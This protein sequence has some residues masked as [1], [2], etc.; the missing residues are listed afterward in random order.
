MDKRFVDAS[1]DTVWAHK[2]LVLIR[3]EAGAP[4]QL[5]VQVLDVTDRQRS[6]EVLAHQALHDSLTGLPNRS[7]LLQRIEHAV[8][9]SRRDQ[10][11]LV[12]LIF[13]DLDRFKPINDTL[14]HSVGD[15][16]LA[17]VARRLQALVRAGDT[18]ARLGGDEFTILAE[19]LASEADA[20][21]IAKRVIEAVGRPFQA[22]ERE[23][24][25]GA[26][27][28]IAYARG[29]GSVAAESLLGDADAAMYEAKRSGGRIVV[30]TDAL[31]AV[32]QHRLDV[33]AGLRNALHSSG[34][35][36][37]YQPQLDLRSGRLVG[38]EALVRWRRAD[39]EIVSPASFI[40][41]AEETGLIVQIGQVVLD[42]ACAEMA[43]WTPAAAGVRMAVN[44]SARQFTEPGLV[45]RV[46]SALRRHRLR[47]DQL[48]L[49]IT[50]SVLMRDAEVALSTLRALKSLGV[51]VAVDD[52][53]TGYSSLAYLQRFPVDRVK[54]D[55]SF[56]ATMDSEASASTRLV[57]AIVSMAHALG[58]D[59]VAE[60]IEDP[61]Q[62]DLVRSVGVDVAQGYVLGRPQSAGDLRNR[63]Q[64]ELMRPA[65]PVR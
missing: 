61:R 7:L 13:L 52:F 9:R 64:Q 37:D 56:V 2:S 22:G 44:L 29:A 63:L 27:I 20:E 32:G 3:D 36:L 53:G 1:G 19:D 54:V 15:A 18:V 51:A 50:E 25:V 43:G 39:G 49:E 35:L 57:E 11:H 48:E 28:G 26:S 38:V 60:G 46:G 30:H 65:Q 62:L 34:F 21:H 33:E 4:A 10:H 31:R 17:E 42:Q 55:R 47:P 40:P 16:V 5:L 12:S 41:L 45:D 8:Q 24:F 14:G 58:M 59:V 23:V 6:Q